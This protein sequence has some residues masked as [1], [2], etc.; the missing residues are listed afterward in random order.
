MIDSQDIPTARPVRKRRAEVVDA[1]ARVFAERGYHG[2]STQDIADILGMRQASLYYYVPSKEAALEEVCAIATAGCAERAEAIATA[3]L[4]VEGRLRA[5]LI[6]QLAPAQDRA[7]YVRTYLN[8][9]KW[10]PEVSRSRVARLAAQLERILESVIAEGIESGRFRGT[11]NPGRTALGLTGMMNA[12]VMWPDD[13]RMPF[14]PVAE[15]LAD[16]GLHAVLAKPG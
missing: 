15:D 3:D 4:P 2:A 11:L 8:E 1:A 7:D 10:L 6:A 12:A 5:L 9:R 13:A 16:L 14:D